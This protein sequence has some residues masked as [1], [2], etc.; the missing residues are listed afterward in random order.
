MNSSGLNIGNIDSLFDDYTVDD[1]L[2]A[3]LNDGN[4]SVLNKSYDE[5]E[6]NKLLDDGNDNDLNKSYEEYLSM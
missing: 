2:F 1:E 6:F 4:D 5:F 3:F